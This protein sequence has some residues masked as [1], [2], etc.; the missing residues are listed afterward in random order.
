MLKIEFDIILE[1][2]AENIRIYSLKY[3]IVIYILFIKKATK[4]KYKQNVF[5][6]QIFLPAKGGTKYADKHFEKEQ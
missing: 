5:M 4:I 1:S 6:F 3:L 2:K